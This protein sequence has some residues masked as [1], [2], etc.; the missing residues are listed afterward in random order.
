MVGNH[1]NAIVGQFCKLFMKLTK[2]SLLKQPFTNYSMGQIY[3]TQQLNKITQ[4]AESM[5]GPFM[6][7]CQI[8]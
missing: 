1:T 5:K 8:H 4:H 3:I 6:Q 7:I 2:Q